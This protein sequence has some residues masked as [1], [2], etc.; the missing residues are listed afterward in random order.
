MRSAAAAVLVA[1]AGLLPA[2]ATACPCVDIA[3][4][5]VDHEEHRL[6]ATVSETSRVMVT[7]AL[8][9]VLLEHIQPAYGEWLTDWQVSLYTTAQAAAQGAAGP[10]EAHV[11]DYDRAAG[12]LILWPRLS[13]RRDDVPLEIR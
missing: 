7:A 10:S 2:T 6:I 1:L 11:A 5:R 4:V 3:I 8:Y 13:T 9:E 12:Q